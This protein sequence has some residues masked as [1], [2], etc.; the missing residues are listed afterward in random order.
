MFIQSPGKAKV[1]KNEMAI[2]GDH[3]VFWFEV[4]MNDAA[5]VD[6]FN[7]E[8]LLDG[9]LSEVRDKSG[10]RDARAQR[11]IAWHRRGRNRRACG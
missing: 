7:S 3:D 2:H 1:S 11:H 9:G 10:E 8:E 5:F 6:S 4:S